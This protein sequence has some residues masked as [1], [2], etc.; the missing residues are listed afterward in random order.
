MKDYILLTDENFELTMRWKKDKRPVDR[1]ILVKVEKV[2]FEYTKCL[3][4]VIEICFRQ[5]F[6]NNIYPYNNGIF[7]FSL[8]KA[9]MLHD[10][11]NK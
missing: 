10:F 5:A 11:I 4:L 2:Y 6:F 1:N 8:L 3:G 7:S 9:V